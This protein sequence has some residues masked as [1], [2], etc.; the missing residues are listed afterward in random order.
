MAEMQNVGTDV[1]QLR[2][3]IASIKGDLGTLINT[4]KDLGVEQGKQL[5][6]R[7]Q[8]AGEAVRGQAVQTQEQVGHYIESRP[9]SSVLMAFGTGFALGTLVGGRS[10]H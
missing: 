6:A 5:Y 1:G 10:Y 3:D 7:A 8:D 4:L 2:Q 9:I